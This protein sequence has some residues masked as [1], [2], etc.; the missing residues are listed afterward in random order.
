MKKISCELL[1]PMIVSILT[2]V[3]ITLLLQKLFG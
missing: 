1:I 2:S 3:G